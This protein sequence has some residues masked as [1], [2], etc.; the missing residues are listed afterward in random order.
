MYISFSE[1]KGAVWGNFDWK[2]EWDNMGRNLFKKDN[3]NTS[4]FYWPLIQEFSACGLHHNV[5]KISWQSCKASAVP[6][7][8]STLLWCPSSVTLFQHKLLP[9]PCAL[10]SMPTPPQG[11]QLVS[12]QSNTWGKRTFLKPVLPLQCSTTELQPC[13][14]DWTSCSINIHLI[15]I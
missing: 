13:K 12:A 7:N 9:L 2:V 3:R 10:D 8:P 5:V 14:L 15:V 6:V 4:Y 11:Q 1:K